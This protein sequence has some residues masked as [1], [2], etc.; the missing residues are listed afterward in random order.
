MT[1]KNE[2]PAPLP[3]ECFISSALQNVVCAGERNTNRRAAGEDPVKRNQI[4]EG[5]RV[6]FS[7]TGFDAANM[8]DITREAGVS[9]STIYVYF[10]NKEELFVELIAR[11]RDALFGNLREILTSDLTAEET[12]RQ[13]G[14][15]LAGKLLS[16]ET[17][18]AQRAVVGIVGRMPEMSRDFY[19][20]GYTVGQSIL[21][22]WLKERVAR[23]EM[24]IDDTELAVNQ[25]IE[26]CMAGQYRAR[27]F[28]KR[29]DVLSPEELKRNVDSAIH[30]FCKAYMA[31]S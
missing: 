14:T 23:G 22:T 21:G 2:Q 1:V 5:A 12:L 4:L 18:K 8:N 26:L 29:A 11:E 20:K 19:T 24:Q 9:K 7:R 6:V 27:L 30:I 15:M 25:F 3:D 13:Y 31:G 16:E 28:G 10:S 17:I